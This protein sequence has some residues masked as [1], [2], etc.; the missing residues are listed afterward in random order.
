M[1]DRPNW[2]ENLADDVILN[3]Q[4]FDALPPLGCHY[5]FHQDVAQWEVTV[6]A[7]RT[8]IVGGP[9]DGISA[10]AQL[11]VNL[12]G[13]REL[14]TDIRSFRW[15]TD[16]VDDTDDLGAHVSVEGNYRGNHVWLRVLAYSPE[17]I[18]AG[19]IVRINERRVE[20][21]WQS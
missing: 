5:F 1:S 13:L 8:E 4:A 7:A 21:R 16:R 10:E 6:F 15:Q 19:R 18:E 17:Q 3:V 14:F 12:D 2:L 9:Y 11:T 20:H